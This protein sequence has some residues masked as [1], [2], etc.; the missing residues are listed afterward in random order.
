MFWIPDIKTFFKMN[1]NCTRYNYYKD[2]NDYKPLH[3]DDNAIDKEKAK[4]QNFTVTVSFGATRDII[5]EHSLNKSR[6]V[7]PVYN[8]SVYTFSNATNIMWRHGVLQEL[9]VKNQ[10]RISIVFWGSI[11]KGA[12]SSNEHEIKDEIKD[13]EIKDEEFVNI[14]E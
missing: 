5:F 4:T 3:F 11:D 12:V 6:I 9:P 1:I 7:I 13:E 8:G 2:T 14:S 10:E